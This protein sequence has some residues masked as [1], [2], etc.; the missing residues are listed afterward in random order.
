MR[1][2]VEGASERKDTI[3]KVASK[4]TC[5]RPA[6]NLV[7]RGRRPHHRPYGRSPL[8]RYRGGG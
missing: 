4:K 1:S 5:D 8:P 6:A 2:M 3:S 7:R